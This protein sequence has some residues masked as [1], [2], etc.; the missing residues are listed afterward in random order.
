DGRRT[1]PFKAAKTDHLADHATIRVHGVD[2]ET[3]CQNHRAG[4]IWPIVLWR[5]QTPKNRTQP[6]HFKVVA[7]NHTRAHR[8]RITQTYNCEIDRGKSAE[9][10]NGLQPGVH[11]LDLRNGES[12]ILRADARSALAKVEQAVFIAIG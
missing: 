2:P 5:E 1:R 11:I 3:V 4:G 8:V 7:V 12:R 9:L 10:R 6:H